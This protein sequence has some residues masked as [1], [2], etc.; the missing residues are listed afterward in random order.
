LLSAAALADMGFAVV[1]YANAALQAA[2]QA[3]RDVLGALRQDGT[4]DRV[5]DRVASFETRQQTVNKADW[6]Q[7]SDKYSIKVNFR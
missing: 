5:Y 3:M 2:I 4:L 7:L 1:L 6:D